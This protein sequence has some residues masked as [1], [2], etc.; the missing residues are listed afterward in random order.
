MK[1]ISILFFPF[2]LSII[3]CFGQQGFHVGLVGNLNTVWIINQDAYGLKEYDYKLDIGGGGGLQVG[4][5][6][7]D[8]IGFLA[9]IKSSQ[10]GQKYD[11]H[12]NPSVTRESRLDYLAVPIL[13]KFI[14]GAPS[15]GVKFYADGGV[16]LNFL[17]SAT[18]IGYYGGN[19]ATTAAK[20][21]YNS[22]DAG[23]N[24]GLGTDI[25]LTK[26]LYLNAGMSFYY[27]FNDINAPSWRIPDSKG[28]YGASR[29]GTG[30]ITVGIHY[31]ISTKK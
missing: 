23:I 21:R 11:D 27:S 19:D 16:Q 10:E 29:N 26:F 15:S 17:T 7:T 22:S 4:Y 12:D 25:S 6:I 13:F 9:E 14:G 2:F 3:C 20:D 31:L 5:N 28:V 24:F 18:L 8:H 1:K 30:G